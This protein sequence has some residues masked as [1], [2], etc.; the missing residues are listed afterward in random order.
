MRTNQIQ[1]RIAALVKGSAPYRLKRTNHLGRNLMSAV[2]F[3]CVAVRSRQIKPSS[4][5][6]FREGLS[7][8]EF[9]ADRDGQSRLVSEGQAAVRQPLAP[10]ASASHARHE[11]IPRASRGRGWVGAAVWGIPVGFGLSFSFCFLL[12]SLAFGFALAGVLAVWGLWVGL[13]WVWA[14]LVWFGQVR[15]W[16]GF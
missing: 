9:H 4:D 5:F 10:T 8:I 14:G 3:G 16:S 7:F 11:G 15:F 1:F 6:S 2:A 13:V 12:L